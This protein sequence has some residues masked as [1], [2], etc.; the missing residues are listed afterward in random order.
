VCTSREVAHNPRRHDG[1]QQ[2][3]SPVGPRDPEG[4]IRRLE[5]EVVGQERGERDD[6]RLPEAPADCDGQDGEQIEARQRRRV[7]HRFQGRDH[8]RYGDDGERA[9]RGPS[10]HAGADRRAG[11]AGSDPRK[12]PDSSSLAS[13]MSHNRYLRP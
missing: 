8:Q 2:G 11:R 12:P 1:N 4:V 9:G 6:A 7:D 5:E 3:R 10:P 13:S